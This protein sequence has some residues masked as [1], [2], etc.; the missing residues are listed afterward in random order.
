V[1]PIRYTTEAGGEWQTDLSRHSAE[2]IHAALAATIPRQRDD[3]IL[4][5]MNVLDLPDFHAI[6]V[7]GEQWDARNRVWEPE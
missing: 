7:L 2:E 4:I 6:R 3:G 1:T 5:V